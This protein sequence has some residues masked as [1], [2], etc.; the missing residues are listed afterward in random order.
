MPS[1]VFHVAARVALAGT[2]VFARMLAASAEFVLVAQDQRCADLDQSFGLVI[3]RLARRRVK[4]DQLLFCRGGPT[5]GGQH[6][7]LPDGPLARDPGAWQ[8]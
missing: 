7:G 3:S 6:A 2:S 5:A 1:D 8:S 4:P